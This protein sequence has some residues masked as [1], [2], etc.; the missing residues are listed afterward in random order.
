MVPGAAE[1]KLYWSVNGQLAVNVIGMSI[2]GTPSF[3]NPLADTIGAAVKSAFTTQLAAQF[4]TTSSLL[5]VGIRDLRTDNQ[6][7]FRDS[8]AA[9]AG[10]GAGEGLPGSVA[11]CVTLR[12]SG[13]GKSFRGRTYL[14]GWNEGANGANGLITTAAATAGVNFMSAVNGAMTP[15]GFA[16]AVLTRPQEEKIITET[17]NHADGT[18]TVRTLSHQ[19]AKA[20]VAHG[21]AFLESRN[22][23]WESQRRRTNGR[24]A[25]PTTLD[26]G[27][28]VPV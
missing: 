21:L 27:I 28:K 8:G 5:R 15:N 14:S 25:L 1:L 10:T 16:M 11:M 20:G 26:A 3:G 9:V 23:F 17:T 4:A 6:P 12:T 18:T 13:A 2:T 7:E 22:S 24:G 19:T